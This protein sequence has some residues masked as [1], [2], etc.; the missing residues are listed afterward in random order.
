M[1]ISPDFE[2]EFDWGEYHIF[3][4]GRYVTDSN[5]GADADGNRGCSMT[6]LEDLMIDVYKDGK[7]IPDA[8]KQFSKEDWSE[9]EREAESL[10]DEEAENYEPDYPDQED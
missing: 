4:I 2:V 5:Y 7:L 10:L 3:A 9:I 6:W 1:G 8:W